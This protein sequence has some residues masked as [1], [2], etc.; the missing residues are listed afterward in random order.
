VIQSGSRASLLCLALTIIV[1]PLVERTAISVYVLVSFLAVAAVG[2]NY[3][4]QNA[5][6]GSAFDR[7]KGGGT[8]QASSQARATLLSNGIAKFLDHPIRGSGWV[9]T[10]VLT[11]HNV[12][13]E[14]GIA[15][16]VIAVLA[17]VLIIAS[18][19]KPLF[20]EPV[21]N[22][23]AFMG[24]SYAVFAAI[25]PTIYDRILWGG[26]GLVFA[27]HNSPDDEI[28]DGEI[29]TRRTAEKAPER[30]PQPIIARP[31]RPRAEIGA[32][33]LSDS[34]SPTDHD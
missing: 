24:L 19:I 4:I 17:F 28:E 6:P 13:L 15:G 11:Y 32:R 30:P 10:D 22:R 1:W 3:L 9:V 14:V 27:L 7:L 31:I 23:L 8:A 5:P 26:L 21:P 2:A 16:G 12:Y 33:R 18:T 29:R 25:G 20:A 34:G